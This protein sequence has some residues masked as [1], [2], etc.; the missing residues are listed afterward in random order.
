MKSEDFRSVLNVGFYKRHMEDVNKKS[1]FDTAEEIFLL[2]YIIN[3]GYIIASY[4]N[5]ENNDTET[6]LLSTMGHAFLQH[7]AQSFSFRFRAHFYY[8][9]VIY[10]V[11]FAS[12][13]GSLIASVVFE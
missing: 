13:I 4:R 1:P 8:Y 5:D 10:G 11:I 3:Q 2:E 6:Y 12:M 7:Y 9:R